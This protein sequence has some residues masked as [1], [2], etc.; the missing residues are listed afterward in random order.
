MTAFMMRE[1]SWVVGTETVWP[2]ESKIF[3]TGPSEGWKKSADPWFSREPWADDY[4]SSF[5]GSGNDNYSGYRILS[6]VCQTLFQTFYT[7]LTLI[8]ILCHSPVIILTWCIRKSRHRGCQ[9]DWL[10][11]LRSFCFNFLLWNFPNIQRNTKYNEL[12][13]THWSVSIINNMFFVLSTSPLIIPS[14]YCLCM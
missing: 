10:K 14:K 8:A 13:G 11:N 12:L 5:I 1:Q 4:F 3:T 2:K 7:H 6:T 9:A